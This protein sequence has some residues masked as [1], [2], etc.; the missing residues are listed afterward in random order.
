MAL[1]E[2]VDAVGNIPD[3]AASRADKKRYSE[4][5][6][7][8]LSYKTAEGLRSVGFR[9]VK[10]LPGGPREK[11]FH[12]GLGPKKVDVSYSD[13]RHG[14]LLAV[15]IKT[16]CFPP[17]G[18]NLKNRFG[19]LL[20]EAITLHLRFPY[21]VVC[22]LFAFPSD[23]D[24]DVTSSRRVSTF[25]KAMRLFSTV[26]GRRQY[27]DPGEKFENVTLMLFQ[28]KRREGS[29]VWVRLYDVD[30]QEAIAEADYFERL[31]AI[32]NLRNPHAPVGVEDTDEEE[33]EDT[34]E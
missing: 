8:H 34:N 28:P 27:T 23:A 13:E 1:V 3:N 20:T 21:S 25:R 33:D 11:E 32:Y 30:T 24:N 6:S 26:S 17:F 9:D 4:M 15:S 18:K 19:D 31:R 16:I 29:T 12:G 7:A 10:P 2:A 5:L 22:A 14:L